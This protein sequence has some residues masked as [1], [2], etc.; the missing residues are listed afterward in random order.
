MSERRGSVR[1][2]GAL[3][4]PAWLSATVIDR[5]QRR[6]PG[7]QRFHQEEFAMSTAAAQ[8]I[9]THLWY[10]KDA[11]EA[12]RFYASVFPAS[13]VD[14]VTSLP[15]ET[16]SGP[17]GSVVVVEFTLCG[18]GFMAISAGP[19]DSFNDAVSL[20]VNCSSQAEI[21]RYWDALLQDGG[22]PQACGWI[23][24]KYGLRWQIVPTA[25]G[26]MIAHSDKSKAKRVIQEMLKQVKFDVAR[27]E[28][29]FRG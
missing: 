8:K 5:P 4:T 9:V 18:Q 12:A 11:E 14:R 1:L 27:L 7:T 17:A 3:Q 29:A 16:P 20:L 24:D 26:E 13:R 25:L 23:I 10:T 2:S 6:M 21:D 22:K 15:A 19:H 28:A